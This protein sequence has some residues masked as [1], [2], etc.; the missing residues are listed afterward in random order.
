M[1]IDQTKACV[2][3][4]AIFSAL[5]LCAAVSHSPLSP[6]TTIWLDTP[7]TNFTEGDETTRVWLPL[8]TNGNQ[9]PSL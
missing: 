1:Q 9:S 6:E 3:A 7:A 4:F 2:A 5:P 8:V